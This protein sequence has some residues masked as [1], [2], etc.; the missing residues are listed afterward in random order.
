VLFKAHSRGPTASPSTR[1]TEIPVRP[2]APALNGNRPQQ[3]L[4]GS[5]DRV[6]PQHCVLRPEGSSSC[7]LISSTFANLRLGRGLR[8]FLEAAKERPI[9]FLRHSSPRPDERARKALPTILGVP[10]SYQCDISR[11]N[12]RCPL[13]VDFV[14][15][16]P[17]LLPALGICGDVCEADSWLSTSCGED[18]R[19]ERN[20]LRQFPEVLGCGG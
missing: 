13:H 4:H 9:G 8:S 18:G 16:P 11:C 6:T 19:R 2:F 12:P 15:E 10:L 3:S 1:S 14:E 20:E 7:Y 17:V 5:S